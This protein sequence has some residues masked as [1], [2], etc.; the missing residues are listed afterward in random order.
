MQFVTVDGALWTVTLT[1]HAALVYLM[2][3]K[4][5]SRDYPILLCYFIFNLVDDP[6][7][8]ILQH[9]RVYPTFYFTIT[10]LDYLFQFLIILEIGR[11]VF[12]P[13]KRSLP[14]RLW[15]IVTAG[16]LVCAI[17]AAVFSPQ[18][19]SN[20]SDGAAHMLLRVTLGLAILKLLLFAGMAGFAQFLGISWK[21]R[22]LQLASGLA[23]YGAVSLFVQLSSSHLSSASPTYM[24][25]LVRL[26]Q[27]Q[28]AAYNLT[29]ISWIWAFSRNEAPRKDFTPQMQEVLVTIAESAK[30][31]RLAVTRS[32]DR[33]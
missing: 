20:G 28:S 24:S 7:A 32:T 17:V 27:I 15:P 23:F 19:Q 26:A 22:V 31:T 9:A 30:R 5:S 25:H 2:I 3:R 10:V 1:A 11:N 6:L 13:S 16:I 12:R 8:W 21:N 33:R 14:F 29:L 4:G 18:M